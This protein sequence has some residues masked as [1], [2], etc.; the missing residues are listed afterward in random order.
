MQRLTCDVLD[1]AAINLGA[2]LGAF[3]SKALE[4]IR[5]E[6]Y[7]FIDVILG[8]AQARILVWLQTSVRLGPTCTIRIG[9][10]STL[11]TIGG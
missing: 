5:L 4:E 1:R 7:I 11:A 6:L 3:L 8:T 10:K 9:G 2:G